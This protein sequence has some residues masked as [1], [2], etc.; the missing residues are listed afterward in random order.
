MVAL[1]AIFVLPSD[2]VSKPAFLQNGSYD[3]D[4]D[5]FSFEWFRTKT[6]FDAEA[7]GN[8][9]MAYPCTTCELV[10]LWNPILLHSVQFFFPFYFTKIQFP[11]NIDTSSYLNKS[12]AFFVA[13]YGNFTFK[14][15]I[16]DSSSFSTPYTQK[17]YPLDMPLNDY[18]YL[19]YSVESSADLVI[20]AVNCK[21][22]KDGSFYSLPQYTIIENGWVHF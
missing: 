14:M 10:T 7:Q 5:T 22:T 13:G 9:E 11:Q 20:M 8:S 6:R 3:H 15:D 19:G 16:Y 4:F 17:D 1:Q 2:S 21:A 12:F 18:V